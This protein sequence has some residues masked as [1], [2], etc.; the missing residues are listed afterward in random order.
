MVPIGFGD[1]KRS[2]FGGGEGIRT[3]DALS[4]IAIFE[5]APFNHSGTPPVLFQHNA[6]RAQD[7]STEQIRMTFG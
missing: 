4:R 7:Q 1:H 5:T 6:K 3:P 2:F